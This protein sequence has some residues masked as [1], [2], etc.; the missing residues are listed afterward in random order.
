MPVELLATMLASKSGAFSPQHV[1][2]WTIEIEGVTDDG[3]LSLCLARGFLP[4]FAVDEVTIPFGNENVYVAGR[5]RFDAGSIE[6]RDYVDRD[7]QGLL[8][9]WYESVYSGV[10]AF[11]NG[12]VGVPRDYKK[13]ADILFT[14]PNG[15]S[16]RSWKLMGVW[17]LQMSFGNLDMASS[18][19]VIVSIAL[20]YDKANYI[21]FGGGA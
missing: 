19:Q 6:V 21:G 10:L 2:N 11:D 14:E 3:V 8:T 15:E 16:E 17:P 20:R 4:T 7:T 1:N 18:E 5:A 13:D 9:A 12:R